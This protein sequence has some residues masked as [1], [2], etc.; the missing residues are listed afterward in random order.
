MQRKVNVVQYAKTRRV[1]PGCR[2]RGTLELAATCGRRCT[3]SICTSACRER[4]RRRYEKAASAPTNAFEA[5]C[6]KDFELAGRALLDGFEFNKGL[7]TVRS[8][9]EEGFIPKDWEE[10]E[11]PLHPEL[12][13]LLKELPR[14][15]AHLVFPSFRSKPNVGVRPPRAHLFFRQVLGWILAPRGKAKYP[16]K[17]FSVV[18]RIRPPPCAPESRHG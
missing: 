3:A 16:R 18:S 6:R 4:D 12:V 14:K 10:R 9:P 13:A 8:K 7:L 11:I 17:A 5:K 1:G 2:S 15:H